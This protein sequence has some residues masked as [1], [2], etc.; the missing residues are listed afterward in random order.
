M[1]DVEQIF[2]LLLPA[3]EVKHFVG[4][5]K[6]QCIREGGVKKIVII[7]QSSPCRVGAS[8]EVGWVFDKG[9]PLLAKPA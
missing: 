6:P 4:V 8:S 3:L 9:W 1:F 5:G 2:S 7:T